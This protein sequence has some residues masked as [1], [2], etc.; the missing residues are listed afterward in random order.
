MTR[1]A[2]AGSALV[3]AVSPAPTATE[4]VILIT[5]RKKSNCRAPRMTAKHGNS[6]MIGR[7]D[8]AKIL[9]WAPVIRTIACR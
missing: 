6:K 7:V 9:C 8:P 4:L 2:E 5:K 1:V 3:L